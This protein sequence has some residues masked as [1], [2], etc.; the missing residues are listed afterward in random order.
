MALR[1]CSKEVREEPGYIGGFVRKKKNVVE[2]PKITANHEKQTFQV[3][4]FSASLYMGRCKSL[5]SLKLFL[6]YAP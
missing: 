3:K 5:R 6:S 4:D 1:S 2:H